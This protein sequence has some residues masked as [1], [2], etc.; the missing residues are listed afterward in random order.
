MC[1]QKVF[2]IENGILKKRQLQLPCIVDLDFGV[3]NFRKRVHTVQ[4]IPDS[5]QISIS[6][7]SFPE[8][9]VFKKGPGKDEREID[10][11]LQSRLVLMQ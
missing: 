5:R 4:T 2:E 3:R 10:Q 7:V 9:E 1:D 11:K 8:I 6:Q